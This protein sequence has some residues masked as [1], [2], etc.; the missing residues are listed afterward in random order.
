LYILFET[1]W[2]NKFQAELFLYGESNGVV[3]DIAVNDSSVPYNKMFVAGIFDTVTKTSQVQLCSF[4][5]WD[6]ITF[7]KV[8]YF[9]LFNIN[10][11]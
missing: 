4:A 6:G 9:N 1:R 2:S 10:K 5:S 11:E 3:F 7:N 8:I